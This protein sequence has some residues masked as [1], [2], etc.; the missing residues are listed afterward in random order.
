MI[1][2]TTS[3]SEIY[4]QFMV[5]AIFAQWSAALLKLA[6]PQAGER[7]LDLACGTG[8]VA[9]MAAPMVQ[10][11][12]EV[13]GIDLNGAQIATARAIDPSIDWREGDAG[14]LPFAG[15][16]FGL[17]V[18]QQGFQFF[19]DRAAALAEMR[20]AA[21]SGGRL[22]ISVWCEIER[23]PPFAA[24]AAALEEAL[25]IEAAASYRG[26]PWGFPD[27]EDLSRE[28]AAAG[29]GD[30]RVVTETLPTVFDGGVDQLVQS[31]GVSPVGPVVAALDPA[32]MAAFRESV[33]RAVAPMV[34]GDAIRTETC[35]NTALA[36]A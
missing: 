17:V 12:G 35:S 30:V 34:D 20:R 28:V 15:Q 26:G 33:A 3:P 32:G 6:A 16:E 24:V 5:P 22:G 23:C 18:C 13:V 4:E 29:F 19:P 8:V 14:S 25:G 31:I 7:T 10:P 11:G 2:S 27:A 21:R 36:I 9:R 1:Q